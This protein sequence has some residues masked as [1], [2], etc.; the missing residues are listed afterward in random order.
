MANVS[1]ARSHPTA[2]AVTLP[3][4]QSAWPASLTSSSPTEFVL[5]AHSPASLAHQ[6][7]AQNAPAVLTASSSAAIPVFNLSALFSVRIVKVAQCVRNVRM[8]TCPLMA[9]VLLVCW[10]VLNVQ[11]NHLDFA[12]N[13]WKELILTPIPANVWAVDRIASLASLMAASSAS[14]TSTLLPIWPVLK[15]VSNLVKLALKPTQLLAFLVL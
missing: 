3:I 4:T 9:L 8:V 2:R 12:W 7:T 5:L 10:V 13:A 1:H 15:N 6:L 11:M 14:M